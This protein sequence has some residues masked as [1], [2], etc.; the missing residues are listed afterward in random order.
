MKRAGLFALPLLLG[1]PA[2]DLPADPVPSEPPWEEPP[3]AP[4]TEPAPLD[5]THILM[6]FPDGDPARGAIEAGTWEPPLD[7]DSQ[8]L[9]LNWSRIPLEDGRFG[10]F[11]AAPYY[12]VVDLDLEAGD[13]II[14]RTANTYGVW[15][16][17]RLQPGHYYTDGRPRV[18]LLVRDDGD[19]ILLRAAPGREVQVQLWVTADELVFN[20]ADVTPLD[21][22][23]GEQEQEHWLGVPLLNLTERHATGLVA[24]VVENA[25]FEGTTTPFPSLGA[26]SVSQ[27]Q[28]LLRPKRAPADID[29]ALVA[30]LRVA[31][32]TMDWSYEAEVSLVTR[33][34]EQPLWRTFRSPIDGSVQSFGGRRPAGYDPSQTYGVVLSLHGAGVQ[35]RGQAGSYSPKAEAFIVAPTN[36]HPFGFDHEEWG[37]FND[38]ATLDHALERYGADPTR[39]YLT[40]HSMGGH[41]TWHVGVTTPGRF[42]TVMPS[43][44]WESFYSYEGST[45]PTGA[46]ARARAHSSTLDYL[47]NL[48]RRGAYVIHGD[49]DTNVPV[50][51][52]RAMFAAVSE[53]TDD[54]QYHEQPGAGHWWDADGDEP[55]ADCVDWEPG[56]AWMFEHT[57]DPTELD[58][59][60]LSPSPSYSPTHSY[61]TIESAET[62]W[63]D[64]ELRSSVDGDTVTLDTVNARSLRLDGEALGSRGVATV[65]VDG[66]AHEVI[67]GPMLIG[68]RSGKTSAAYGP[69]NQVF[70]RPFCLVVPDEGGVAADYAAY[71]ASAWQVI[72]SGRACVVPVEGVDEALRA[73]HNLVWVGVPSGIADP[74]AD[75]E[76]GDTI[77]IGPSEWDSS[78]LFAIFPDGD[79][80]GGVMSATPDALWELFDVTPWSSRAGLP[81]YLVL[82]PAGTRASGFWESDWSAPADP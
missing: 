24:R 56:F 43:A 60:F 5:A 35:A 20:T 25:D 34:A 19:R 9:G 50:S 39:V 29:D 38:L 77:R 53:I 36:R 27:V 11:G 48:A 17:S 62:A 82:G 47:S 45:R 68:T 63:E 81:D 7:G 41:G 30:T 58:F 33:E 71:L 14:A 28:F 37:R 74:D 79:R 54:A 61:A 44:G 57:L 21:L 18:P 46:F 51:E 78:A 75:L 40:G 1:C 6:G 15:T 69:L 4:R 65:I 10:P 73:S 16:G 32:P 55:G 13:R 67:D 2:T 31:S 80:L 23:V 49:A 64:V 72:G 22:V 26:G 76:W 52:G 70:R 59:A 42:A 66:E 12:A 8:V 3:V